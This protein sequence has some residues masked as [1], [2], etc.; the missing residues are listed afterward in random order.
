MKNR[1]VI[2]LICFVL[3][4]SVVSCDDQEK[5]VG[6]GSLSVEISNSENSKTIQP[7]SESLAFTSYTIKGRYG[8]NEDWIV[9]E[10]F[11]SKSI[12][13]DNL[14]VGSWEFVVEGF[15]KDDV[16]LAKSEPHSVTIRTNGNTEETYTLD[17]ING[18]GS[19]KLSV[20][21]Q[22]SRISSIECQLYDGNGDVVGNPYM[23]EREDSIL[24]DDGLYLFEKVFDEVSTGFYNA[25]IVMKDKGGEPIGK[26]LHQS[27]HI[28][29][30]LE[31]S[32]DFS[33]K[34]FSN[35]MPQVDV[36]KPCF[37]DGTS[38]PC[39]SKIL[40]STE[41]EGASIF[42]S[43]DG[44]SYSSYT[45]TGIDLSQMQ[46]LSNSIK[47]WVY[48]E[49]SNLNRSNVGT[50]S[51][52]IEHNPDRENAVYTWNAIEGGYECIATSKCKYHKDIEC[53]TEKAVVSYEILVDSTE[54]EEGQC[55]YTAVFGKEGYEEPTKDGVVPTKHKLVHHAA[56]SPTCTEIGWNEYDDCL[57]CSYTTRTEIS[58]L[59]HDY[60]H[61]EAKTPTCT[62]IGWR[63]YDTCSRCNYTTYKKISARGHDYVKH[64]TKAA[65]CTEI[66]WNEYD[67]CTRCDYSTKI[68]KPALG[69]C[70]KPC[71]RVDD[72]LHEGVCNR[73]RNK[74]EEPHTFKDYKCEICDARGKGPSG[75]Y[76]FYDRGEKGRSWRYLEAAPADLRMVGGVP[77]VD[78]TN[79]RYS[80][81]TEKF[82]FGYYRKTSSGSNVSLSTKA[83]IGEGY[84][85]TYILVCNMKKASFTSSS[86]TGTTSS[87][88]ARLCD[89]LEYEVEGEVFKDWFLPSKEELNL[90][91]Q[92]LHEQGLG[93]FVNGG[94][95]WSS[96][97][98]IVGA[99]IQYFGG[100]SQDNGYRCDAYRVRP[101]RAF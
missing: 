72:E 13:I 45:E 28:Q 67:T 8:T 91:Y 93:S 94:L 99:W 100:G 50:Y 73:C 21:V 49:K 86:G 53:E 75:G 51:F 1:I 80:S 90:M 84:S 42:Y 10:S 36:P 43:F 37:E 76:V 35:L 16:L 74:V 18:F 88:A 44:K 58:A 33:W 17:W 41:E 63:E 55:L 30:G 70:L 59:E 87:Y 12:K 56:K 78:S 101:V 32:F 39:D 54:H 47:I 92:N 22:S 14:E 69:H 97:E 34:G 3:M 11:S 68:E 60:V 79:S 26:T 38:I 20:K 81:G 83:G 61:H 57:N 71:K 82:I 23:M 29:D 98:N 24:Q 40:L 27:V 77:T 5:N 6:Y 19:L 62:E 52:S 85:N 2:V 15:N 65:T 31:S 89:I 25:K 66:G 46:D 64:E 9:N 95:Y 96:S 48:A 7:T 4:F